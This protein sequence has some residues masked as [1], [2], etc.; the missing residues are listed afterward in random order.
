[1]SVFTRPGQEIMGIDISDHIV[2]SVILRHDRKRVSLVSHAEHPISDGAIVRGAIVERDEVR[3]SVE[4][5][6]KKMS[7]HRRHV[8]VVASLPEFHGFVKTIVQT[9]ASTKKE[10]EKHLPFPYDEVRIDVQK[11]KSLP[12]VKAPLLSFAAAKETVADSYETLLLE[13]GLHIQALEIESQAQARLLYNP[14]VHS[15]KTAVV[16]CDI[17][18]KHTTIV[19]VQNGHIDF[20]YTSQ[21][22]S[23]HT[24]TEFIAESTSLSVDEAEKVKQQ[25]SEAQKQQ[26]LAQPMH[27]YIHTFS[28]E[29]ERVISFHKEHPSAEASTDYTVVITG[30][31]AQLPTLPQKLEDALQIP[32]TFGRFP[33]YLNINDKFKEIALSYNTALGLA[34]RNNV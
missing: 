23:G 25:L 13:L 18:K 26:E 28:K 11:Y 20:T 4:S 34:L 9:A 10:I 33:A 8:A 15:K 17:G 3:D 30:G 2:R 16:I 24:L 29:L 7:R 32:V 19:L 27:K 5:V 22:I 21:R 1:M 6:L 14:E 31:G 12:S